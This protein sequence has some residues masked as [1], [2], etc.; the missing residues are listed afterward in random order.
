MPSQLQTTLLIIIKLDYYNNFH[1]SSFYLFR[2][3]MN[4]FIL[5]VNQILSMIPVELLINQES[6]EW[7][8]W[9]LR[10]YAVY[11]V[12]LGSE[13]FQ[14]SFRFKIF[15][16]QMSCI[17]CSISLL[18]H[19]RHLGCCFP[20]A[21]GFPSQH[22][23]EAFNLYIIF[24]NLQTYCRSFIHQYACRTQSNSCCQ[25][26]HLIVY[27]FIWLLYRVFRPNENQTAFSINYEINIKVDR[28]TQIKTR[29]EWRWTHVCETSQSFNSSE[30]F[31]MTAYELSH[32]STI[33]WSGNQ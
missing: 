32:S 6:E 12:C 2:L 10:L 1:L 9:V 33:S 4:E 29:C 14:I 11:V 31:G 20:Q 7:S 25:L 15:R 26:C 18:I 24:R 28:S 27:L 3:Q 16:F 21:Y 8:E 13:S 19:E 22:N 5:K 23:A 17:H 30:K